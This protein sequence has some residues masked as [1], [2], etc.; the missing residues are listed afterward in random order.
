M[1]SLAVTLLTT[2]SG[3]GHTDTTLA[4]QSGSRLEISNFQ[5]QVRVSTW[6]KNA[7]RVE[8]DHGRRTQVVFVYEGHNLK[9]DT[10]NERGIPSSVDF[11]IS[12]PAWMA[13]D[14]S[15]T[16]TDVDIDGS[17]GP[18]KVETVTGDIA[19]RGGRDY[20]ELS[21]VQGAVEV[22]GARGRLK[23]SSINEGVIASDVSGQLEAETVNGEIMLDNVQ[24]DALTVSSVGGDV[25][26]NGP[27]KPGG[28][29]QIESH[30]GDVQVVTADAPDANLSV[31]TFSGEFSSDFDLAM[32]GERRRERLQ[33]TLGRGGAELSLESFNG[34]IQLLK[35]SEV[36]AVRA[37]IR[38]E[39]PQRARAPQ[40]PRAPKSP[41]SPKSAEAPQSPVSPKPA[42][43]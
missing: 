42:E 22:A 1:L 5:G 7:V 13:L 34:D 30:S 14:I 29:Y 10:S 11:Q 39:M 33:F 23:L 26:F 2:L 15:G 27:L 16:M 40:A 21:S 18:V 24:L 37:R 3:P 12:V 6:S 17:E 35:A 31:S 43:L 38:A 20:V 41:K 9:I 8:A 36:A 19:V 28:R 32:H 4:V 25:W